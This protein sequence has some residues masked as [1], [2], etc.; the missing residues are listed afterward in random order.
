MMSR[1][2]KRKPAGAN[3][4][5]TRTAKAFLLPMHRRDADA[6]S[7]Q[8]RVALENVRRQRAGRQEATCLAQVVLL[9]SFLTEEGHGEIDLHYI[10]EVENDVLAMLDHGEAT[11]EWEFPQAM[12]DPLTAIVNEHDRQLREVRLAAVAA[13]TERLDRLVGS[14]PKRLTANRDTAE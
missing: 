7:L 3:R 5:Q 8:F 12:L 1:T 11:G 2:K 13:A 10:R 4:T 9:T 14:L 6:M